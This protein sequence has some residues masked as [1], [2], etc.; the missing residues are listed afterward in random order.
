MLDIE[1]PL[2][3]SPLGK[4]LL[5]GRREH[6]LIEGKVEPFVLLSKESILR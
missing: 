2:D 6:G 5:T 3:G 1:C 4:C